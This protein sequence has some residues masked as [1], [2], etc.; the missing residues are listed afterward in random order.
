MAPKREVDPAQA[1]LLNALL[2]EHRISGLQLSKAMA[3]S[4]E[5]KHVEKARRNVTRWR[6]ANNAISDESAEALVTAFRGLGVILPADYF[7]AARVRTWQDEM[8][9][10]W[11][12]MRDELDDL[13]KKLGA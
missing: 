13:R 12:A 8:E 10:R 1:N 9:E 4:N 5:K 6:N 3:E 2:A 11:R 7:K